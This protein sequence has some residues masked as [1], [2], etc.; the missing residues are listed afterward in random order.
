MSAVV[1]RDHPEGRD[2]LQGQGRSSCCRGNGKKPIQS[3]PSGAEA[4]GLAA[5]CIHRGQA[6]GLAS[7]PTE[8]TPTQRRR[9]NGAARVGRRTA[10][11]RGKGCYARGE[12]GR[13][14]SP[15][16]GRRVLGARRQMANG[17]TQMAD[18]HAHAP[19]LC[20]CPMPRYLVMSTV[21]SALE[22]AHATLGAARRVRARSRRRLPCVWR[23]SRGVK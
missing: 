11:R 23:Q 16:A 20:T 12:M 4:D 22:I 10:E 21:S 13:E 15:R 8:S 9:N 1:S 17:R 18:A 3:S 2:R 6:R 7:Q 5:D 14:G 19:S